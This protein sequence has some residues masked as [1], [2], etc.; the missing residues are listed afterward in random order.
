MTKWYFNLISIWALKYI[1]SKGLTNLK[2]LK[3]RAH[4]L[5]LNFHANCS[6]YS[7]YY[8]FVFFPPQQCHHF[9]PHLLFCWKMKASM[10]IHCLNLTGLFP[11]LLFRAH[12]P[13]LTFL[14]QRKVHL[15]GFLDNITSFLVPQK[16]FKKDY[17]A[18]S[19]F[20]L[21]IQPEI[22]TYPFSL[23]TFLHKFTCQNRWPLMGNWSTYIENPSFLCHAFVSRNTLK[24]KTFSCWFQ[25]DEIAILK[26]LT[27][28]GTSLKIIIKDCLWKC[29]SRRAIN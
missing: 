21:Y 25:Q 12:W 23:T 14:P 27:L 6:L 24:H 29:P 18:H 4:N 3:T 2:G 5:K 7:S 13:L 9:S 16:E 17:Q 1:F 10:Q 11:C 15:V 22:G 28:T 26:R 19:Y 8:S 20:S